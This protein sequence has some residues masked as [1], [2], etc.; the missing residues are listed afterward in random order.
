MS[1]ESALRTL[2]ATPPYADD[3]VLPLAR[4]LGAIARRW[5]QLDDRAPTWSG[6][7]ADAA[8]ELARRRGASTAD[9][10]RVLDQAARCIADANAA[11]ARA[12]DGFRALPPATLAPPVRAALL[13][14]A[15]VALG[16]FGIVPGD[17]A[18]AIIE[19][20]LGAVRETAAQV[21]LDRLEAE[22]APCAEALAS[23]LEQLGLVDADGA[24]DWPSLS[25]IPRTPNRTDPWTLGFQWLL[26]IGPREQRFFDGDPMTE[27]VKNDRFYR[28]AMAGMLER[29]RAGDVAGVESDGIVYSYSGVEGIGEYLRDASGIVFDG[30]DGNIAF[31]FLGSHVAKVD[32]LGQNSDGSWTVRVTVRNETSLQS[33][34]RPPV[35]GYTDAYKDTIGAAVDSFSA[36]TGI[37]RTTEQI[38]EW[39]ETVGP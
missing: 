39:T 37:G 32:V 22:L 16:P 23:A 20:G 11:R 3:E 8:G 19:R 17:A 10:A 33:G 15:P 35:I 38:I 28:E 12:A 24:G 27:L 18:V 5:R 7:A 9:D 26:G 29:L 34:T 14:G 21:V 6:R 4:E 1:A 30:G 31:A 36:E 13:L 25:P 2:V